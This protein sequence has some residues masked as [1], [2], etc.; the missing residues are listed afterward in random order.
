MTTGT[1]LDVDA[2][3]EPAKTNLAIDGSSSYNVFAY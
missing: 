1:I 3:G 2:T